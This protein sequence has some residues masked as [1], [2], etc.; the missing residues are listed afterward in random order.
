VPIPSDVLCT[1]TVI[2]QSTSGLGM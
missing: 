2:G 1:L